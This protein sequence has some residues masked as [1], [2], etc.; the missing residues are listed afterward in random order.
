MKNYPYKATKIAIGCYIVIYAIGLLMYWGEVL[1][2]KK[3]GPTWNFINFVITHFWTLKLPLLSNDY[4]YNSLF[5]GL[6][7]YV[8]IGIAVDL[9]RKRISRKS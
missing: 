7:V 2:F 4:L 6:P 8:M 1:I 3:M 5:L 9:F